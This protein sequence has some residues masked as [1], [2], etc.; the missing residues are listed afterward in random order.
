MSDAGDIQPGAFIMFNREPCRVKRREIVTAGTHMH[1]KLKFYVQG[2]FSM[3]EKVVTFAHKD[4]VEEAEVEFNAGQLIMITGKTCQIM[5]TRTYETKDA[6]VSEDI[7]STL[8]ENDVVSYV[9]YQGRS[10]ILGRK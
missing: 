7:A 1:S 5:D 9:T 6:E 10:I 4:N 2:L 8:K 3:Q